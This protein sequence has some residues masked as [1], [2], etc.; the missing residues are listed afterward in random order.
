MLKDEIIYNMSNEEM[1][2]LINTATVTITFM[3]DTT[4][5]VE[6]V[7]SEIKL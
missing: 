5:D 6:V 2:A 1:L 7:F 4:K 3:D